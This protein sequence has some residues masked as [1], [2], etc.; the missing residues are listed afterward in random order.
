MGP[1]GAI[2]YTALNTGKVY[3]INPEVTATSFNTVTPCRIVDTRRASGALGGPALS[4]AAARSFVVA[5]QCGV[6]VTA[7]SI[8][9]NV[10]VT[11]PSADGF[12]TVYPASQ[13]APPSSTLNFRA[14]QTRAN[15][16]IVS[17]GGSGD[18]QVLNGQPAG[19]VHFILDVTG[20]F[21]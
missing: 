13:M 12:L 20:Y 7:H 18:I 2:Y 9:V 3:R 11:A 17:L 6:P 1:D 8:A 14:G 15:N 4:A 5:G 10:T 21:Q 16:A 19:T